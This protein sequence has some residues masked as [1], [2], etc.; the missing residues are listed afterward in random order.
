MLAE[1]PEIAGP[2]HRLRRWLW[3]VVLAVLRAGWF[4][5]RAFEERIELGVGEA[6]EREVEVLG[7][8]RLQL[9][10]EQRVVPGPLLCQLVI[11]DAVGAALSFRQMPQHDHRRFRQPEL[12][13]CQDPA[14]AC[15]H[16]AVLGDQ[17][18]DRPAE[19]GDGGGDPRHLVLAVLLGV[20]G[21][22]LQPAERPRLDGLRRE[23]EGHG[24]LVWWMA[25]ER[26]ERRSS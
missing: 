26:S 4:F 5:R 14:V 2:R 16:L 20:V 7:Q 19:L 15:D 6:G 23:P 24:R 18:R 10:R 1:A 25:V 21:V 8:Q 17:H 22:G 3:G 9:L 13:G 12:L 11:R